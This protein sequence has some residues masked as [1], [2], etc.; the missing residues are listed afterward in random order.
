M[1]DA[2]MSGLTFEAG[3]GIGSRDECMQVANS[4]QSWDLGR[5]VHSTP[6]PEPLSAHP[7]QDLLGHTRLQT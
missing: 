2:L 3:E 6:L 5:R 1:C 4:S 7:S